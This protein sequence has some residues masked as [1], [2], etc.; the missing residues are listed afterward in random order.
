MSEDFVTY[1]DHG[2]RCW[3]YLAHHECAV[4]EIERLNAEIQLR[5]ERVARM[6]MENLA[7]ERER[8]EARIVASRMREA[9]KAVVSSGHDSWRTGGKYND[10]VLARSAYEGAQIALTSNAGARVTAIVEAVRAL[11]IALCLPDEGPK[12][13][14]INAAR[15]ALR[16]ALATL[17]GDCK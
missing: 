3:R 14:R 17:D 6:G 8:D 11:E 10:V 12:T 7:F 1:V 13:E 15:L 5:D 2:P 4:K 9:L 16:S